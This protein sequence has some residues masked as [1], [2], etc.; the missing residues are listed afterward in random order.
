MRDLFRGAY[1]AHDAFVAPASERAEL[2]RLGIGI[3]L[4]VSLF[5]FIA[6]AVTQMVMT[7]IGVSDASAFLDEVVGGKTPFSVLFQ[8]G[9]I[10][11][12]IPAVALVTIGL[13]QRAPMSLIG[14]PRSAFQQCIVVLIAQF[15]LIAVLMALPPYDMPGG[16]PVLNHTF[17]YWLLLLPVSFTAVALQCATEEVLF[18][19]YLQQQLAARFTHPAYWMVAP[20]VL[21]AVL[22]YDP[23]SM[24]ENA[25]IIAGTA[26][27]F[28]LMM[29]DITARAGTLGPAIAMHLA[30]NA[31]PFLFMGHIDD[32]SGLALY[33]TPLD[34]KSAEHL[35]TWLPLDLG[36]MLVS[37]LTARLVLR[38]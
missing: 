26:G 18:R 29:A 30:N 24:G 5:L 36:W 10:S 16:T 17:G 38:R 37:W 31:L 23:A 4:I 8:L 7:I 13:H 6:Q 32:M 21:F 1:R 15:V 35:W 25:L 28:G 3:V 2:W 34:L 14:D 20:S 22:H 9:Q 12:L 19:G 11:L 27:L 33:V